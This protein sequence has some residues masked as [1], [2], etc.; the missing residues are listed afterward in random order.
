MEQYLVEWIDSRG[1][2]DSTTYVPTTQ[3]YYRP[4]SI[5]ATDLTPGEQYIFTVTAIQGNQ[6]VKG[7]NYIY[8]QGEN[9][10]S[11]LSVSFNFFF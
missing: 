3:E 5:P 9:R 10:S 2:S 4:V 8:T 7:L 6:T 11:E 1:F